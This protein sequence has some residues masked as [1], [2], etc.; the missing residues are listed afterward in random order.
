MSHTWDEGRSSI[1]TRWLS[2]RQTVTDQFGSTAETP[3]WER[4]AP[5]RAAEQTGFSLPVAGQ[6]WFVHASVTSWYSQFKGMSK[7]Q[8]CHEVTGVT[9]ECLFQS[10]WRN[11]A[12][13]SSQNFTCLTFSSQRLSDQS[14]KWMEK[15]IPKISLLHITSKQRGQKDVRAVFLEQKGI[16][17]EQSPGCKGHATAQERGHLYK[18]LPQRRH[19]AVHRRH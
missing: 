9:F 11:S 3:Y 7:R 2:L 19:K 18:C 4:C 13:P 8:L 5:K 17:W 16:S 6:S 10:S 15:I 14:C 1:V 12:S